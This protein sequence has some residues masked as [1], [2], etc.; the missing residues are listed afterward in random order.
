MGATED[1]DFN[2]LEGVQLMREHIDEQAGSGPN[3]TNTL[4]PKSGTQ[5]TVDERK[6][7]SEWLACG[8]P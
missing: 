6:K 8:A 2:T 3:A 7:L 5:P 4:M 1:H